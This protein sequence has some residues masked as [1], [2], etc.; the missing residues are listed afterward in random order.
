LTGVP[1][2]V[3]V[4]NIFVIANETQLPEVREQLPEIPSPGIHFF[5][6][7]GTIVQ[8]GIQ[9][10]Y[11]PLWPLRSRQFMIQTFPPDKLFHY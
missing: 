8:L 7:S 3:P 2:L 6:F 4:E 11:R 10:A 1:P 5:Q 9:C